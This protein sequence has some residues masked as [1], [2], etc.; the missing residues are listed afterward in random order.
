MPIIKFSMP[1]DLAIAN[2]HLTIPLHQH[3]QYPFQ[4]RPN[5]FLPGVSAR[6]L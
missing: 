5:D 1:L 2:T 4:Q 6:T 3:C